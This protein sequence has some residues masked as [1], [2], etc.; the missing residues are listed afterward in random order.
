MANL[1]GRARPLRKETLQNQVYRELCELILEGGL[2]P[3]ESVT[4]ASIAEA[5]N[6]SPMP[7]REALTRLMEAGALT[8]ISGRSIGVPTPDPAAFEDLKNVR[9]EVESTALR[10][11]IANRDAAFEAR[12]AALLKEMDKA[13]QNRDL[14]A[15][16]RTNYEFHFTIYRQSGS[17][18]LL[19]IIE[20]FWL[21]VGPYFHALRERGNLRVS[22][23]HHRLLHKAICEGDATGA[24]EALAQDILAAYD[25]MAETLLKAK[26]APG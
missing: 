13:E 14:K 3:G 25:T 10:W 2:A 18:L 20:N 8:V 12:L 9:I 17:P 19:E 5:F 6:V 4:V 23:T 26:A 7:V 11:A 22:N 21:R 15:H 1:A 24:T 16:I